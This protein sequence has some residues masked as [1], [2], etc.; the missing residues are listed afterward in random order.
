ML[1]FGALAALPLVALTQSPVITEQEA[2]GSTTL[3]FASTAV[4][5][6]YYITGGAATL[7]LTPTATLQV[8]AQTGGASTLTFSQTGLLRLAGE[9]INFDMIAAPLEFRAQ[10]SRNQFDAISYVLEF[11]GTRQ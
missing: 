8:E 3:T 2:T 7:S 5:G 4:A 1:G 9:P 10:E 6:A 11:R